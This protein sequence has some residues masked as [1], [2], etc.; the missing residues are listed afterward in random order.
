MATEEAED[1]SSQTVQCLSGFS[2]LDF[3]GLADIFCVINT[4]DLNQDFGGH[5]VVFLIFISS[6]R[7][8]S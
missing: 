5:Y 1:S 6:L 8:L 4:S 7:Y 3:Q 2:E